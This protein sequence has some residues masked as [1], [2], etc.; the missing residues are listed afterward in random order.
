[1][2]LTRSQT[3]DHKDL[4]HYFFLALISLLVITKSTKDCEDGLITGYLL[5]LSMFCV[6]VFFKLISYAIIEGLK[7]KTEYYS[8]FFSLVLAAN[9]IILF[10]NFL[11]NL[12][13]GNDCGFYSLRGFVACLITVCVITGFI[14]LI[15]LEMIQAFL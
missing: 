3:Q 1:M 8:G 13:A 12:F 6:C 4:M 14:S 5:S 15:L 9:V 7:L 2:Y 10:L 11:Y